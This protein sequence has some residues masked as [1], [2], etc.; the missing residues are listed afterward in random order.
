MKFAPIARLVL[1]VCLILGAIRLQAQTII[2]D[3][4]CDTTKLAD[5][6]PSKFGKNRRHYIGSYFGVETMFVN[7]SGAPTKV[8]GNWEGHI[9]L[10]YKLKATEWLAFQFGVGVSG[11]TFALAQKSSKVLPDTLQHFRENYRFTSLGSELSI[12]F[13]IPKHGNTLG[14]YI[15]LGVRGYWNIGKTHQYTDKMP[16]GARQRV[17]NSRLPYAEPLGLDFV[18]RL[19]FNQLAFVFRY[20]YSNLFK[21]SFNRPELP[22][23]G[24]GIELGF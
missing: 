16:E 7:Q 8:L 17:I 21:D 2:L 23:Y 12:R 13:R 9:G 20:R 22:R 10:R 15:D 24:V 19:G 4:V 1:L 3:E 6:A 18:G 11:R 5:K 14:R